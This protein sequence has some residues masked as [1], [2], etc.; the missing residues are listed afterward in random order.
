[1]IK[2]I[3]S[4]T[5]SIFLIVPI[6]G[7]FNA[8]KVE[9][10]G[11]YEVAYI[12]DNGS[13]TTVNTFS[14]F[15]S[16]LNEMKKND[17]YVVRHKNSYS[18]TK[19]IAM[20]SGLVYS[21]PYR[22]GYSTMNLYEKVNSSNVGTGITTYVA[23]HYEMTYHSTYFYYESKGWGFVEVTLN[24]FHGYC[25]LE[26]S[27]L[28]PTKYIEKGIPITLG[29]KDATGSNEQPFSVRVKQN[30]YYVYE[31][32]GYRDLVFVYH[33]AWSKTSGGDCLESSYSIGPAPD[34]ME[35]GKNYY[36]NDGINFY[37]DGRL[38]NK[39]GTYYNYYQF[40]PLRTK[41]S[42]SADKMNAFLND[43]ATGESV[44]RN[45]GQAFIDAQNS[46]G[47]NAATI[48]A[49]GIH[50]SA[51]GT[52]NI[53]RGKYNLFGWGAFD[54]AT[55]NATRYSSV[56]ACV[57]A[58]M[59]DNLANYM[60]VKCSRY[61]SMSLGNK[62]GG[63]ILKYAS[64]PY[65]AE[66]I[67][68]IYYSLDKYAAG[69]KDGKL[70]DYNKYNLALVN[71]FNSEVK[72]TPNGETYYRTANKSGY[73][74]NLLVVTLGTEGEYT[75]VQLSNPV[76]DGDVVYPIELPA[77]TLVEYDYSDSVGYIKT[78][79]LIILKNGVANSS[80]TA[81]APE[82]PPIPI[83]EVDP[84][85]L[86]SMVYIE[87]FDYTGNNI[88]LSGFGLINGL[89]FTDIS[90]I[91][92]ELVLKDYEDTSNEYAFEL[93]TVEYPIPLDD[94]CE[95]KYVGFAGGV[96]INE[97]PLGNYIAYLR[98]TNG[99]YSKEDVLKNVDNK[100]ANKV[101]NVGDYSV[102]LVTNRLFAYRFE[103]EK[104]TTPIDYS[105]I[106]KAKEIPSVF[107]FDSISLD[108]ELN[109]TIN[110]TAFIQGLDFGPDNS[111]SYKVY[112]VKDNANYVKQD[113]ELIE[114]PFDYAELLNTSRDLSNISYTAS[115][116]IKD[117]DGK[118][119]LI[120]EINVTNDGVTYKDFIEMDN[121]ANVT[122]PNKTVDS[123]VY[124]LEKT[125]TRDR[126]VLYVG[127]QK[128]D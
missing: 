15:A 100:F 58:Q 40:L 101:I 56:G 3:L 71:T 24:G 48:F 112:L 115:I 46:Y 49:M 85:K 121:K 59:A 67:A 42:I 127:E 91:K 50:E 31:K 86:S 96:N 16:A 75:K 105:T 60:D 2:K 111:V 64:D 47:C 104:L 76:D 72:K 73:Q 94:G 95:Y 116:N 117:L 125:K 52:S 21:Y 79:D 88:E 84:T 124:K 38:T 110:A 74:K 57:N 37:T 7:Y 20:N 92:H 55:S 27:D 28:V 14:D 61:F 99:S 103:I 11:D 32:N 54:S 126:V 18:P 4:L 109:L 34:F 43:H 69:G 87:K 13:L 83:V 89:N 63:F 12:E 114:C 102:R 122:L 82:E 44:M 5:L 26:Y 70:V 97:I 62:G 90:T 6:V 65:W 77:G 118:Y 80:D 78:S 17:D 98:I 35:A 36:S 33:R 53:A 106:K 19:I 51:W 8:E 128:G 81:S 68:S 1:M 22:R 107:T 113:A 108:D 45:Q 93:T 30:Y 10:S 29:G 25:D 39:A 9:A 66:K 123:K 119:T 23:E 120:T 41:T